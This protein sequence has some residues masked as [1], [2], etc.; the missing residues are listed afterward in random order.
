ME[1]EL[2]ENLYIMPHH[3]LQTCC[4]MWQNPGVKNSILGNLLSTH[5][6]RDSV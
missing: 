6:M 5:G 3:A 2:A 1:E 4:Q